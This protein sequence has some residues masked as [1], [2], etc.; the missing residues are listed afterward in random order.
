M[1][2]AIFF[3]EGHLGVAPSLINAI[4]ALVEKGYGVDVITNHPPQDFSPAPD[5]GDAVRIMRVVRLSHAP[6]GR[7]ASRARFA[8]QRALYF[9]RAAGLLARKRYGFFFGV[10]LEGLLLAAPF[11]R[12]KGAD[13]ALWSLE[14]RSLNDSNSLPGRLL[15]ARQ[16][17][18]LDQARIAIAQ[19][20]H[21]ADALRDSYGVSPEKIVVVPNAPR[22]STVQNRSRFLHDRFTLPPDARLALHLGMIEP[23]VRATEVARAAR[24]LPEGWFLVFHERRA[25]DEDDPYI[26]LVR[27]E[28]GSKTLLSLDPVAY[29]EL[30]ELVSSA[31]VGIV[32]YDPSIGLNF[33]IPG[34]S[35][36]LPQYLRCGLPVIVSDLPGLADVVRADGCGVVISEP[37]Q[38]P[39]AVIDITSHYEKLRTSA[40]ASFERR[41]EFDGRFDRALERLSEKHLS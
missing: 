7:W 35:G 15:R 34:S 39:D 5:F 20:D 19:D 25:R 16:E 32:C 36:K 41:Y 24:N 2:V 8:S 27:E 30:D 31:D 1:R 14:I 37:S 4:R 23:T 28:G 3:W 33:A 21:R 9:L 26:V 11:A 22:G 38:L 18:A 29:D 17:R 12:L 10:D 13:L 40:F 6:T